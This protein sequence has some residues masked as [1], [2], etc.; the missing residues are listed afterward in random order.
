MAIIPCD[1]NK[2][3]P[4]LLGPYDVTKIA[5]LTSACAKEADYSL[6]HNFEMDFFPLVHDYLV[7]LAFCN[8]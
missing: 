4:V 6:R 7:P 8:P 2:D 1:S 3:P 5:A